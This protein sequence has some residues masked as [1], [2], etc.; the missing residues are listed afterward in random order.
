M[1]FTILTT[2][3]TAALAAA[4]PFS[5]G[6]TARMVCM[7]KNPQL[8]EA[9]DQ[10]C[11]NTNVV[12]PSA[13]GAD[14]KTVGDNVAWI[15]PQGQCPQAWVPQT[16]CYSQFYR[17]CAKGSDKGYGKGFFGRPGESACQVW[18]LDTKKVHDQQIRWRD[19]GGRPPSRG[20]PPA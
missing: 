1:H 20:T 14:G 2:I 6:N 16:Y 19:N 11:S 15:W 5:L 10:F 4:Q 9:I 18:L 12:V 7:W 8:V 17:V 13:Y 3:T